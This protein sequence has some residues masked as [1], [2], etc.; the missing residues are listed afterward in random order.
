MHRSGHAH[1]QARR[2]Y[3]SPRLAVYGDVRA[4]TLSNLSMNMNDKGN[5]SATM[6]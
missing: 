3:S 1:T 6:T 5:G 2:P 4:L